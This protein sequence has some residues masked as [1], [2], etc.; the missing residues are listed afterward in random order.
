MTGTALAVARRRALAAGRALLLLAG[1]LALFF[2][3]ASRMGERFSMEGLVSGILRGGLI[4]VLMVLGWR[5]PRLGGWFLA[6]VGLL[7]LSV[8]PSSAVSLMLAAPPLLV[9]ALLIWGSWPAKNA[10]R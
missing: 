5:A 2:V 6:I 1:G 10:P 8:N 9:S 4:V 3:V 7:L